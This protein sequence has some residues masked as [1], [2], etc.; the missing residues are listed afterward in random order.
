[1]KKSTLL[2]LAALI[3]TAPAYAAATEP[4]SGL[5]TWAFLGFIALI[6]VGQLIPAG[7]MIAGIVKGLISSEAV[8]H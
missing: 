4:T 1:M 3:S 6:V 5:L 8:E 7:M 2:T